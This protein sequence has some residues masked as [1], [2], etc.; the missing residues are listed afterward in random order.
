MYNLM[1]LLEVP[2]GFKIHIFIIKYHICIFTVLCWLMVTWH[3]GKQLK[4]LILLSVF[5]LLMLF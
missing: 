5:F 1:Y 2:W 3:A 4:H